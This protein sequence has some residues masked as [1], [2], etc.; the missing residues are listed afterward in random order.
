MIP[1]PRREHRILLALHGWAGVLFGLLALVIVATGTVAVFGEEIGAWS[2]GGV[3]ARSPLTRPVDADVK[4][5]L[6]AVPPES[7]KRVDLSATAGHLLAV[8]LRGDP[9]PDERDVLFEV[10]PGGRIVHRFDGP[11]GEIATA[12][13]GSALSNFLVHVHIR[14]YVPEPWGY[15]VTGAAGL[16]MLVAAVSGLFI[17]RHLLRDLFT[18]RRAA[19]PV[20]KQRDRHGIVG[21]WALP[22]VVVVALT[23]CFFSFASSIGVPALAWVSF[24]GDQQKLLTALF[25]ESPAPDPAPSAGADLDAILADARTRAASEPNYVVIAGPGRSDSRVTIYHEIREGELTP[26]TLVYDGASGEFVAARPAIGRVPSFGGTLYGLMAPLHFGHFAGLLSK[27]AWAA[28]G[29][30]TCSLTVSGL[31]L[32]LARRDLRRPAWAALDRLTSVA[33]FGLPLAIGAAG[34]GFFTSLSSGTTVFW[35]GA[36]FCAGLVLAFGLAAAVGR[37]RLDRLLRAGAGLSLLVLPVLRLA[38]GGP[39]WIAAL[40][41]GQSAVAAGDV[42]VAFIGLLFLSEPA[43]ALRGAAIDTRTPAE[44]AE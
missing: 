38:S 26:A 14:L 44:A 27:L 22:F 1:L 5:L 21:A 4:R 15:L 17:H 35:T 23:G 2:S 43:R 6:A 28:L 18:L 20:L 13:P 3:E 7:R 40:G 8:T 39:G 32:W 36:G 42:A 41:H 24:A 33:A 11:S 10:A 31:R 25:G 16:A 19:G 12:D 9:G 37:P 30:A 34:I 29:F